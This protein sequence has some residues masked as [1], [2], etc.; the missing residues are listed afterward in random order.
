MPKTAANHPITK[1]YATVSPSHSSAG[2]TL[3]QIV[4]EELGRPVADDVRLLAH[5]IQERHHGAVLAILFYGSC[6]RKETLKDGVADFYV[7]VDSY[8]AAYESLLL[9]QL[10][11]WLTP[12]VFYLETKE[13]EQTLR[14]KYA[15]M[16]RPDFVHAASPRCVHSIVWARFCQPVRLVYAR[17]VEAR[18]RMIAPVRQAIL[19]MVSR[20]VPLLPASDET[21]PLA[22]AD[23][24]QRGFHETY[25]MEFRPEK[26]ETIRALY[27]T[28]PGRYDQVAE[29]ALKELAEQD[30]LWVR[31]GAARGY[32]SVP[33]FQLWRTR[34]SWKW[35]RPVAKSLYLLRL[36]KTAATFGEWFPYVL[37][38][39]GRHRGL[40]L[41]PSERQR[42]HPFLLGVPVLV[43]LLL[44]RA[45]R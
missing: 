24:W 28:T 10:N 41:E 6:L 31:S 40:Q 7:I 16:S 4:T 15:V 39:V 19:T 23:L 35:R 22:L 1:T 38:K 14:A 29:V 36:I 9:K 11:T 8:E 43:K 27:E 5:I 2:V 45:V 32:V 13:G 37:W 20:I 26:A 3:Q 34:L 18:E 25:R 44:T 21:E 33:R 30:W 42:Q 12:N 17:D